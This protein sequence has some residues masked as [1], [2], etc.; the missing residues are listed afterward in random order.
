MENKCGNLSLY[1]INELTN[2]DKKQF[3]GHLLKCAKCQQEL[4]SIQ[5]TWQMLSY[6]ADE[7][8]VPESLKTQVMEYVFEEKLDVKKEAEPMSFKERFFSFAQKHFSPLSTAVTAILIISLIGS[9]WNNSQLKD[10][11]KSLE[12]KA[13]DPA[14][15]V[16][17][18]SLK[19]QSLA[20]SAT[21]SAY[22]LQEGTETSLVISLNNLPIT[23]NNEVYQVWLLQNGNRQSAGTLIPDQNGS[24][25]ITYRLPSEYSF[26]DIGITLEPNPFNTQPQGQ[27]V[28]GT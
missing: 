9:Y 7:I 5:E 18:Y 16:T 21:G 6:D 23:K 28:L 27:K 20:A 22:L 11:I 2:H 3:E 25:L 4:K 12:N 8:E 15:I 26:E 19:G 14:Q 1:I 17:T 13:A 10:T 24:G